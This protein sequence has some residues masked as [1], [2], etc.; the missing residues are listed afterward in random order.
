MSAMG[1][2]DCK[3]ILPSND[4]DLCGMIDGM[5]ASDRNFIDTTE[6]C[7]IYPSDNG[8]L[9]FNL[10]IGRELGAAK[11]PEEHGMLIIPADIAAAVY[12]GFVFGRP[13][14]RSLVY[15]GGPL[16][17]DGG[18][19][20]VPLYTKISDLT[21]ICSANGGITVENGLMNGR[22]CRAD[23]CTDSFTRSLTVT[24]PIRLHPAD[25][26]GC[27]ECDDVCP[28]YLL[29]R[30]SYELSRGGLRSKFDRLLFSDYLSRTEGICI[31]CGC[32]GY[33]CPSNIK[34]GGFSTERSECG[35]TEGG[36]DDE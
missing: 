2:K 32:C 5:L 26:I 8:K 6:I 9:L 4:R 3:I 7:P 23:D 27:G 13:Y 22:R 12:D 36:G 10:I 33:V 30:K 25:C 34:L 19:L 1:I 31:G 35:K 15:V 16:V 14:I 24:K 21:D 17:E 29:V 20:S 28:M 11:L 18:C